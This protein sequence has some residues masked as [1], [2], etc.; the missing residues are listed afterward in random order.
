[1]RLGWLTDRW[2]AT[3]PTSAVVERLCDAHLCS[4]LWEL[5]PVCYYFFLIIQY[6]S[7]DLISVCEYALDD[8]YKR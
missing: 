2:E 3:L 1:M 4:D 8:R 6:C 7:L 5:I